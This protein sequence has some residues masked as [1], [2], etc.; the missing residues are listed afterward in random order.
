MKK[1]SGVRSQE[2]GTPTSVGPWIP[3]AKSL[4]PRM[5]RVLVSTK[6]KRIKFA[7]L[8]GR[9]WFDAHTNFALVDMPLAWMH[10]PEAYK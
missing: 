3:C 7:F 1:E 2:S 10:L 6:G 4:P 9:Y 5:S 8:A